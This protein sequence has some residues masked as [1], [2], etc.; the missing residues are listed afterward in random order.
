MWGAAIGA[1]LLAPVFATLARPFAEKTVNAAAAKSSVDYVANIVK[2]NMAL[3]DATKSFFKTGAL[4]PNHLLPSDKSIENL[5]KHIETM[6]NNPDSMLKV[7]GNLG[8]YMPE[9]AS[10]AQELSTKA[11]QYLNS[12][13]PQ[14]SPTGVFDT[15]MPVDKA[16][17]AKYDRQLA[18]AQ[19]PLLVLDHA[20]EGTL[21]AQDVATLNTLF[22]NLR[23]K[24]VGAMGQEIAKQQ[25]EGK[26][27]PYYQRQSLSLLMGMSLDSTQN[28]ANMQAIMNSAAV[29]KAM[30]N[31]PQKQGKSTEYG[32]KAAEKM[33]SLYSTPLQNRAFQRRK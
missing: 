32:A 10:G 26:A 29:G 23:N 21:Q 30:A 31:Q 22:P 25:A 3:S 12:L 27:I 7:G 14:P 17:K 4:I 11:Q 8:H 18:I 13:K 24:I 20:R 28:P 16:A 19:Q 2:G 6:T 9:H 1:K 15:K 5:D 33:S